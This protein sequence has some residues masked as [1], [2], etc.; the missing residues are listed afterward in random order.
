MPYPSTIAVAGVSAPVTKVTATINGWS[1]TYPSDV[2]MLLIG[3]GGQNVKLVGYA[4]GGTGITGVVLTFDDAATTSLTSSAI[5]SG[6]YLPSDNLSSQVFNSPAPASPYGT[7]LTPLAA[8]PNGKWSLYVEDFYAQDSGSISGGWSLKFLTT[9]LTTNCCSTF[10]Q[11]T[12]TSTT[13]SNS[14]ARFNWNSLPGPHYQVQYRTNLL[15]GA[16]QNLGVPIPG[17]NTTMGVTDLIS[18]DPARFYRVVV[19]P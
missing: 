10:P 16:W 8:S 7:T 4:G 2:S 12:L 6:T 11:P 1:H 9:T 3:P 15:T 13:Y 18:N 14:V 5:A 19:S 17:T